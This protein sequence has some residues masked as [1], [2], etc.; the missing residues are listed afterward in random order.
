[1]LPA[2]AVLAAASLVPWGHAWDSTH[3]VWRALLNGGVRLAGAAALVLMFVAYT[4]GNYGNELVNY[5]PP[6]QVAAAKHMYSV[7]PPGSLIL[8]ANDQFEGAYTDYWNDPLVPF[9]GQGVQVIARLSQDPVREL[10]A[11]SA[12]IPNAS[13]FVILART[14][15]ASVTTSS[16]M[17]VGLYAKIQ[18]TLDS[19]PY[20]HT[21]YR[22]TNATVYRLDPP[23]VPQSPP[24]PQ[25]ST[26]PP[27]EVPR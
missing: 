11:L 22:S 13:T 18:A 21:V 16:L 10:Q 7:A 5:S 12:G 26:K 25:N 15:A 23:T 1:M 9:D 14:E 17:P 6:D 27:S 4:F 24:Y 19:S 8:A 2:A 20:A 3:R